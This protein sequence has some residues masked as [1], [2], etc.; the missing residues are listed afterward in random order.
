MESLEYSTIV[1]QSM[2]AAIGAAVKQVERKVR[3]LVVDDHPAIR[4]AIR[5]A[6]QF[7]PYV[8]VCGEAAD[9]SQGVEE[10]TKLK[11]D[12]VVIDVTMPVLNGFEAAREIK[13]ILPE[14][15]IIIFSQNSGPRFVDEA[16]KAGA[17]AY[18]AKK[19]AEVLIN[20]VEA[21]IRNED[22][23]VAE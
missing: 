19:K 13:K 7:H 16:K 21:A 8:E 15:A 12:V 20:A 4:R 1:A 5:C 18:V 10:A 11:P 6:L 9:G 22:F 17:R 23:F 3:L 2:D 14:S